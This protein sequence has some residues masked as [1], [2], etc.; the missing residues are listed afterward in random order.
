MSEKRARKMIGVSH[1][2]AKFPKLMEKLQF[3]PKN[4]TCLKCG[5]EFPKAYLH[6]VRCGLP[7][8]FCTECRYLSYLCPDCG[9]ELK[10]TDSSRT[11]YRKFECECGFKGWG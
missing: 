6:I 2:F 9:D 7:A 5:A 8:I 4:A 11:R 10:V 3:D 1:T